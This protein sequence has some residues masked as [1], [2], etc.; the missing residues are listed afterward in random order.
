[1]VLVS[2]DGQLRQ[3]YNDN[4]AVTLNR[5]AVKRLWVWLDF[6]SCILSKSF[7]SVYRSLAFLVELTV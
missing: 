4:D 1:M 2:Y 7:D 5:H 3:N 6:C